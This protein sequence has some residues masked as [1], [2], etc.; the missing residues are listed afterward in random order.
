[1]AGAQRQHCAKLG[2][3]SGKEGQDI[4][5]TCSTP[6]LRNREVG[7]LEK[8]TFNH[9]YLWPRTPLKAAEQTD[10]TAGALAAA[11]ELY[12]HTKA[13]DGLPAIRSQASTRQKD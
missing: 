5:N 13:V 6:D 4:G 9:V 10:S 7:N 12:A 1:M 3:E 2:V 8:T 11:G